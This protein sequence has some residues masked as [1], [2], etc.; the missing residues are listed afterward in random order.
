AYADRATVLGAFA[1]FL[2]GVFALRV[3]VKGNAAFARP[4]PRRIHG[5]RAVHGEADWM[6]MAEAARTFPDAGGIVIGERYRVDR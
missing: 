2:A 1:A 3:A 5:R 4:A 6:G